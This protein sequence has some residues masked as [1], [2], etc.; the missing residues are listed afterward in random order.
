VSR[1]IEKFLR[2]E[3]GVSAIEYVLLSLGFVTA[4]AAVI[5]LAGKQI[6]Q[7]LAG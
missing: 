2:D 1:L 4:I 6:I 7:V 5:L 3:D